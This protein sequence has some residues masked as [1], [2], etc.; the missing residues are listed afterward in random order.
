MSKDAIKKEIETLYTDEL[1]RK[2]YKR[3]SDDEIFSGLCAKYFIFD[4]SK[5]LSRADFNRYNS[6]GTKD[7]GIDFWFHEENDDD[8]VFHIIQAK[9]WSKSLDKNEIKKEYDKAKRSIQ[10]LKENKD[11]GIRKQFRNQIWKLVS[12]KDVQLEWHYFQ[13]EDLSDDDIND[14]KSYIDDDYFEIH[15]N[16]GSHI[17]TKIKETNVI[18]EYVEEFH[19][20]IENKSY[21][22]APEELI[23]TDTRAIIVNAKSK[24]L[25]DLMM[26]H[27]YENSGLFSQNLR[28]FVK[29]KIID[30]PITLTIKKH[31][32]DFWTYNNGIIICC[33]GF[34]EDGD[35]IKLYNFSIINGAQTMSLIRDVNFSKHFSVVCKIIESKDIRFKTNV[36]L[37]SNSQKAITQRD[38]YANDPIQIKLKE[39]L[40]VE[41]RKIT[42]RK[43]D[44]VEQKNFFCEIKRGIPPSKKSFKITNTDIGKMIWSFNLQNPAQARTN[45]KLM[46]NDQDKI[47]QE[48]GSLSKT[49]YQQIF[50]DAHKYADEVSDIIRLYRLLDEYKIEFHDKVTQNPD[51]ENLINIESF[52]NNGHWFIIAFLGYY[53]RKNIKNYKRTSFLKEL[54]DT[55]PISRI[56]NEIAKM[57]TN[58]AKENGASL[59]SNY[60]KNLKNYHACRDYV[61]SEII[62]DD[63]NPINVHTKKVFRDF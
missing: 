30:D 25:K 14:I 6:D 59:I 62:Q 16:G 44:S 41:D 5:E 34:T 22:K 3:P 2:K 27:G 35:N 37:Y 52:L 10:D 23:R 11:A 50:N 15:I 4:P 46:W 12:P 26:Q 43:N 57:M 54:D 61:E 9:N 29:K 48:D 38:F 60:T 36:A 1:E 47:K 55:Y 45:P 18:K 49:L 53:L 19:L 8:D 51:N 20:E 63:E 28:E 21:L 58:R 7:G 24:S 31:P 40:E 33:D 32:E 42:I 56:F 39:Q 17:I 13:A